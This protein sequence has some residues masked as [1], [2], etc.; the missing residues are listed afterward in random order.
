MPLEVLGKSKSVVHEFTDI[1]RHVQTVME[2]ESV[3]EGPDLA[4]AQNGRMISFSTAL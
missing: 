2:S 3:Y 1:L 4:F